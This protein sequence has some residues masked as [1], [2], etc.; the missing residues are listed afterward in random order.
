MRTAGPQHR[1]EASL[2]R[3]VTRP[4]LGLL[5]LLIGNGL[6]QAATA[7]ATVLLV[8]ATFDRV[9]AGG[10]RGTVEA[11]LPFAAGLAATAA[12]VSSPG[13]PS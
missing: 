6:G 10:P 11:L 12:A 7:T 5:A 1:P 4:R 2:P 3:L 8:E 13:L 9:L